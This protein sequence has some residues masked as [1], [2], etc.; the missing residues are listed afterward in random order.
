VLYHFLYQYLLSTPC[1]LLSV[2]IF[3]LS[4]H[5]SH[6]PLYTTLFCVPGLSY[7][8]SGWSG[9]GINMGNEFISVA[10]GATNLAMDFKVNLMSLQ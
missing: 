1:S 10:G 2:L 5:W 8:Y 6:T 7:T 3:S 9:D 4:A